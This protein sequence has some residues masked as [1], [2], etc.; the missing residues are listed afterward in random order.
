VLEKVDDMSQDIL[1]S[2]ESAINN[3]VDIK[4]KLI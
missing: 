2:A 1:M 4:V 3:L